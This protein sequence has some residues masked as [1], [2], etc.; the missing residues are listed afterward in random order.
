MY[1][2]NFLLIFSIQ[3]KSYYKALLDAYLFAFRNSYRQRL[4]I[5]GYAE[6]VPVLNIRD[7]SSV[8][9]VESND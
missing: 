2:L 8:K 4:N 1:L 3:V 7:V 9:A 6:L 5:D